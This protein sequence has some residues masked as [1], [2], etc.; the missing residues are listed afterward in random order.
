ME[1]PDGC[2]LTDAEYHVLTLYAKGYHR[3]Q[4]AKYRGRSEHTVRNQMVFICWRMGARNLTH[5]AAIA[6]TKGWI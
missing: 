4:I 2:P 5:A 6:A 1:V 3:R